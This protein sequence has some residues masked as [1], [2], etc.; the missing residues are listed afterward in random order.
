LSYTTFE[1]SDI[2]LS[3]DTLRFNDTLKVSLNVRNTGEISG[4][5]VVQ[6]YIRDEFCSV[7]RPVKELKAF[8]K[9]EVEPGHNQRVELELDLSKCGYYNNKG[10]YVKE[11][12]NFT[13]MV[14]NSSDNIKYKKDLYVK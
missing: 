10:E 5:E 13:I 7:A 11:A 9:I 14:G 6:L 8:K 1:F 2:K 4:K 3:S 12:G